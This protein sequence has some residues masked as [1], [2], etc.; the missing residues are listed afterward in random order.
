[1]FVNV[2]GMETGILKNLPTSDLYL[3]EQL[4]N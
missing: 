3:A 4:Y 2:E 1:M